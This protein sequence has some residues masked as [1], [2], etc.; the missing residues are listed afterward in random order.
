LLAIVFAA[1]LS[2]WFVAFQTATYQARLAFVGLAALAV[3]AALGLERW[4]LPV[5]FLLPAMGLI[6]TLIAIQQDVLAIHWS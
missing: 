2:I 4:R 3:L 6:G 5:R 1:F